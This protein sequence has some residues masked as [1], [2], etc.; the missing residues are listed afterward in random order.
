MLARARAILDEEI[1]AL[2]RTRDALDDRFVAAFELIAN[3]PGKLIVSGV[4][5]SGLVARKIAATLCSTGRL[6]VFM[7]G[8]DAIHGDLGVLRPED[9]ALLLSYSGSTV[10]VLSAIPAIQRIGARIV[11]MT[12]EMDSPLARAADA[13]IPVA[14]RREACS[15]NLA[16]TSSTA[17][18]MAVGDALAV[19]LSERIGFR[20]EDFARFHP[21][22]ALGRK[23]LLRVRDVAHLGADH[24]CASEDAP[25]VEIVDVLTRTPLG[26]VDIVAADGTLLGL[27][28]D[29]DVRRALRAGERFFSMRAGD[30]MTRSP[31]TVAPDTLAADALALMENRASQISVL[32]VVDEAGR[33]I[34][35]VRVHDLLQGGA[36]AGRSAGA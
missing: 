2:A 25:L 33:A 7:H 34:G 23:L 8:A 15:M 22:G 1:E 20:P 32:P 13:V 28:T 19:M 36:R 17:A 10:E 16:P 27:V 12:G 24:P 29:G 35:L 26:A 4:G 6:A 11:A 5:K 9:V 14:I 30:A 21:G 18:M 31:V 3:S